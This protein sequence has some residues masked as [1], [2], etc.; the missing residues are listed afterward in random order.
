MKGKSKIK[1]QKSEFRSLPSNASIGGQKSEGIIENRGKMLKHRVDAWEIFY[2]SQNG[3]AIEAKDGA[4]DAFKVSSSQGIGLR[5][6]RGNR[7]GFA[8]TS[9][10]SGGSIDELIDNAIMCSEGV[11]P[12][13]FISLPSSASRGTEE[14]LMTLD[15]K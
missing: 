14:E 10:L 2:S 15:R 1:N 6:L 8:F 3:I 4:V 12:D 7:A 5:V 9:M 13:E 11:E